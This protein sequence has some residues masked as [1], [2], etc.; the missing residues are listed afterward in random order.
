MRRLFCSLASVVLV[1]ALPFLSSCSIS[2]P[3]PSELL[4]TVIGEKAGTGTVYST[5]C[6]EGEAGYI[7]PDLCKILF[8][9]GVAVPREM[10]LYIRSGLDSVCEVFVLSTVGA[11]REELTTV[12]LE[13]LSSLKGYYGGDGGVFFTRGLLIWCYSTDKN[14]F[15]EYKDIIK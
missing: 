13:R 8:T 14:E 2:P 10:A 9:P 6:A 7:T 11:E 12:L 3:A 15:E 5:E 1:T 4:M